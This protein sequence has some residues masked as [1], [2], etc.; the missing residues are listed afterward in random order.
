MHSS[1]N[2]IVVRVLDAT[3]QLHSRFVNPNC[4]IVLAYRN[5]GVIVVFNLIMYLNTFC[6][7]IGTFLKYICSEKSNSELTT[8]R[9]SQVGSQKRSVL[10]RV[11]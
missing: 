10:T 4:V 8:I 1:T 2:K 11:K 5:K 6:F 9:F 3:Q 7:K